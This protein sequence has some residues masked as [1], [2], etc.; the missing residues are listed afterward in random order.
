MP[1]DSLRY[2]HSSAPA[3]HVTSA[4]GT[5]QQL[6]PNAKKAGTTR[7][8]KNNPS[9]YYDFKI[10]SGPMGSAVSFT[11]ATKAIIINTEKEQKVESAGYKPLF[12]QVVRN[13]M[14]SFIIHMYNNGHAQV[15]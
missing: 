6:E 13:I 12:L 1:A 14:E 11:P 4:T 9:Y 3:Y 8:V 5:T 10:T 2:K 15:G 7:T